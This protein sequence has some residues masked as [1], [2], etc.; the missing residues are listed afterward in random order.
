MITINIKACEG[1]RTNYG[2]LV[3]LS[4]GDIGRATPAGEQVCETHDWLWEA[5]Q[6]YCNSVRNLLDE[7]DGE[8]V[9]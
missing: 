1:T 2:P 5:G 6:P 9:E 3:I 7:Y 8:V 4:N